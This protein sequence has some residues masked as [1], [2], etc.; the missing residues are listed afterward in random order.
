MKQPLLILL[1][2]L[3][4]LWS[5]GFDCDNY[6]NHEIRDKEITGIVTGKS[7]TS[8]GCFGKILYLNNKT[9]DTIDVCYCGPEKEQ[10]WEYVEKNDSINKPKGSLAISV[11][12]NNIK[13]EFIYPCCSM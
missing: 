3:L 10:I 5:C 11:Y 1:T 9:I 7:K 12:R 13:K 2:S 4:F 8:T 6:L